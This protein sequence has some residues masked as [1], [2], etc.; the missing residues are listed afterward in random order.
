MK[1]FIFIF[2]LITLFA[3]QKEKEIVPIIV[4]PLILF[5]LKDQV[6]LLTQIKDTVELYI[7][8][9]IVENY[10]Y[11]IVSNYYD[12][13]VIYSLQYNFKNDS[14]NSIKIKLL[15]DD[16][17]EYCRFYSYKLQECFTLDYCQLSSPGTIINLSGENMLDKYWKYTESIADIK[18]YKFYYFIDNKNIIFEYSKKGLTLNIY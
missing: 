6:S 5:D 11:L 17:L 3:C 4:K 1:K 14:L 8:G 9:E 12:D 18:S 15:V 7:P 13:S 16:Y 2:S 10:S